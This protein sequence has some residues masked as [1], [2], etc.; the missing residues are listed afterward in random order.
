MHIFQQ[1]AGICLHIFILCSKFYIIVYFRG[2]IVFYKAV[3]GNV[4]IRQ[5][6]LPRCT[7]VVFAVFFHYVL[8]HKMQ[9]VTG[10]TGVKFC[11]FQ[12]LHFQ[13]SLYKVHKGTLEIAL[14]RS[15]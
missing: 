11:L 15:R 4:Y 7:V 13:D 3:H 9:V 2:I 1:P 5:D 8:C 12:R 10:K 14:C 6:S